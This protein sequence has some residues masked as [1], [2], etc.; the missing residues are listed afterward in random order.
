MLEPEIVSDLSCIYILVRTQNPSITPPYFGHVVL[1][2]R[3][4]SEQRY[5]SLQ[6]RRTLQLHDVDD[7][8]SITLN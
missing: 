7:V 8:L 2:V 3:H 4:S 5:L 1:V 6:T